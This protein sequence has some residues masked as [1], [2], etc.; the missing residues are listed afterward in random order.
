M[1][2]CHYNAHCAFFA[3]QVLFSF[4]TM[5]FVMVMLLNNKD[6]GVYLPI[7]S[8]VVSVWMPSPSVPKRN[9][10]RSKRPEPMDAITPSSSEAIPEASMLAS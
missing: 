4:T 3:A 6:T 9:F 5:V 2:E 7:L 1:V 10:A 8:S